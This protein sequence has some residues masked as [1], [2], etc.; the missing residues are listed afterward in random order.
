MLKPNPEIDSPD[1]SPDHDSPSESFLKL[2]EGGSPETRPL[3]LDFEA[4]QPFAQPISTFDTEKVVG[5]I[6]GVGYTAMEH[7]SE[8]VQYRGISR[9][10]KR[11]TGPDLL[12]SRVAVYCGW[13]RN[14]PYNE[15]I[16]WEAARLSGKS[17]GRIGIAFG[18]A[19]PTGERYD[20]IVHAP[21]LT[22]GCHPIGLA[23]TVDASLAEDGRL[24]IMGPA[25][26]GG[27][28]EVIELTKAEALTA[29][30]D[31][32]VGKRLVSLREKELHRP[33]KPGPSQKHSRW[34]DHPRLWG[35]RSL[36]WSLERV[37]QG[38]SPHSPRLANTID[39]LRGARP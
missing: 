16:G 36:K 35:W 22:E 14:A 4:L 1:S 5:K 3:I 26:R 33:W 20:R 27:R 39:R 30:A 18:I 34:Q 28:E 25:G 11:Y 6:I 12:D 23:L 15:A 9:T 24:A 31:K 38:E 17:G 32:L 8:Q 29:L 19:Y 7:P 37:Q 21:Y 13:D 2:V 10:V